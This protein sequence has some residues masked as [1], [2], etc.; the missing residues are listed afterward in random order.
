MGG[1]TCEEVNRFIVDYLEGNLPD[2][3]RKQFETHLSRCPHCKVYLQQYQLTIELLKQVPA[4]DPPP[5]L[6]EETVKFLEQL[7]EKDKPDSATPQK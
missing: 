6:M 3:L 7:K 4:P 1:L 5:E 2:K